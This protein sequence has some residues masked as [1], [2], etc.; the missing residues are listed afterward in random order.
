MVPLT[1]RHMAVLLLVAPSGV[2]TACGRIAA[3]GYPAAGLQAVATPTPAADAIVLAGL[4]QQAALH[5]HTTAPDAILRQIDVIQGSGQDIFR[6]TSATTGHEITVTTSPMGPSST[7]WSVTVP[8]LSPLAT[9]A[10]T[11]AAIDPSALRVGP[12]AAAR[13][14]AQFWPGANVRTLTVAGAGT[15]LTWYAFGHVPQG[16]V[17]GTISNDTGVFR[18][19]PGPLNP[20]SVATRMPQ[21]ERDGE[22]DHLHPVCPARRAGAFS[23]AGPDVRWTASPPMVFKGARDSATVARSRATW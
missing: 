5:A 9:S 19:D 22:C 17:S 1:R 13:V 18:P 6:F 11:A 8:A 10:R 20:P 12:G 15:T 7:Q 14:L 4:A 23:R 16:D 21:A 2:L 3:A